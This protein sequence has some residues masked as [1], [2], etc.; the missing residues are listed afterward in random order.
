MRFFR[1]RRTSRRATA[2]LSVYREKTPTKVLGGAAN[3]LLGIG[4]S[5]TQECGT[6][7]VRWP[8]FLLKCPQLKKAS[9]IVA[10]G[11]SVQHGSVALGI[12]DTRH[13][14]IEISAL[15]WSSAATSW[16]GF[17]VES[18]VLQP[19]GQLDDYGIDHALLGLCV[20]ATA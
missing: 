8:G 2:L 3:R 4:K 17:P 12:T 13:R 18:H 20:A 19:R 7:R 16:A 1:Q 10:V 5:S 11:G 9:L 6:P 15:R 14:P